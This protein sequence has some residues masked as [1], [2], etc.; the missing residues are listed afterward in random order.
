MLKFREFE[1]FQHDKAF[2]KKILFKQDI[3]L[4]LLLKKYIR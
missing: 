3:V 4:S 2:Y 1:C